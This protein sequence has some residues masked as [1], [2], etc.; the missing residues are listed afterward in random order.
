[1]SFIKD[2]EHLRIP[3]LDIKVGTKFFENIIGRG[4]YGPVYRGEISL[5]GN[6]T[7]VAVKRLQNIDQSGQGLKEFLTEINLLSR[8]KHPNLVSLLG[9]CEEGNEKILIYEY[10]KHGSF[11]RYL[12]PMK[13]K[14]PFTWK[15]RM[16]ICVDA[17]RGLD[18]LH[19]HVAENHRVIHRDIKSGNILLDNNWKAMIADLGLSK[20][21]RANENETYLITNAVGTYGYCDPAYITTGILTKESDVYSF[22]VVLLEALCGRLCFMNVTGMQRNL[23]PLARDCYE[24]G[25]LNE[26]MDLDLK[27]AE[28]VKEFSKIAYECVNEDQKARP[29]MDVVLEKLQKALELLETEEAYELQK[30]EEALRMK[31]Y[32]EAC[33]LQK[34]EEALGLQKL[35]EAFQ[36]QEFV[37][38]LVL[39]ELDEAFES[40]ELVE[41]LELH[42]LGEILELQRDY[43]VVKALQ[44]MINTPQEYVTKEELHA[45]LSSGFLT[46]ESK[47]WFSVDENGKNQE[48]ISAMKFMHTDPNKFEAI[49]LPGSRFPMVAK[50]LNASKVNMQV[51]I[52]TQFLS[53]DVTYAAYLICKHKYSTQNPVIKSLKYKLNN[54][55][56]SY[57]SYQGDYKNRWVMMEL[58][59]AKVLSRNFEF[60]LLLEEFASDSFHDEVIVE[61][62]VFSPVQKFDDENIETQEMENPTAT[63]IEW[64]NKLPSDYE[65]FIHCS[66]KRL[67]KRPWN[68]FIT[69]TKEEAYSILSKGIYI[70]VKNDND[71]FFWITKSNGKKCFMLSPKIIR[72]NPEVDKLVPREHLNESR[73][74]YILELSSSSMVRMEFKIIDPLLSSNTT[75]ACYFIYKISEH[76]ENP[77]EVKIKQLMLNYPPGVMKDL[78]TQ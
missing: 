56:Q 17:A 11:D 52:R 21:G 6:M 24:K 1:M 59:Q 60:K 50:V 30:H 77:V 45:H 48:M 72:H 66:G 68:S 5:S 23:V 2:S 63:E 12:I 14:C 8:Y 62:V 31:K 41:T 74:T 32:E 61:G 70:K 58:F 64:E 76:M 67:V 15:Q 19:N 26:I 18:Y 38:A 49:S 39:Q 73:F 54:Q 3:L 47:V 37:E 20:I 55:T 25:K 10:A 16:N 4:G 40:Q 33:E 13:T 53:S 43:A 46:D 34:V 57:I 75:Y 22:G 44:M 65:Q 27:G 36:A 69:E 9:Y 51:T 7:S 42:K 29:S 35:V 71:V 28:S 78:Q